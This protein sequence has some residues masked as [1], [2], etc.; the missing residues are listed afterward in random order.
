MYVSSLIHKYPNRPFLR[1]LL[2]NILL[3]T[4]KENKALMKSA[5]RMAESFLVL[6][7]NSK[8]LVSSQEAAEV[9][10]LASATMSSADKNAAKVLAQKA[11]HIC[12][13]FY[14]IL[15]LF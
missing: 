3:E 6:K 13:L 10:A 9:L 8:E 1:K 15:K 12:P 5:C 14:K 2:A 11:V 7:I 4:Y